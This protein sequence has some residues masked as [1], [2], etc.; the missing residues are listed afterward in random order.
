VLA[1]AL[2][3]RLVA[4]LAVGPELAPGADADDYVRIGK[5]IADGDGIP[6]HELMLNNGGPSALRPPAYPFTLGGIFAITG[7]SLAAARIAQALLGTVTVALLGLVAWQIFRRR[8]VA[9]A[10]MGITAIYPP[11]IGIG[12][13]LMTETLFLPLMLGSV[14]AAL[15]QRRVGGWRWAVAAGVLAGL[16]TL[17]RVSGVYL[18]LPL[19]LLVWTG[20]PLLSRAALR[21]VAAVAASAALV[22]A[23]WTIRNA[24]EFDAFV[25]VTTATGIAF[26][27]AFNPDTRED[28]DH[29]WLPAFAVPELQPLFNMPGLDEAE[30][31]GELSSY[32]REFAF[33]HPFYVVELAWSNLGRMLEIHGLSPRVEDAQLFGF[34]HED[35]DT[36]LF[37]AMHGL[38]TFGFYVL[39][40]L[41]IAGLWLGAWRR[42]PW[43]LWILP[44]GVF[45]G[46][47]LTIAA[48]RY[49]LPAD[50]L[51]ILLAAPPVARIRAAPAA[52]EEEAA[53]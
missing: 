38:N 26:A 40:A 51:L 39:A 32:A 4:A 17:T 10:A 44:A 3:I 52:E 22:V 14:A 50:A 2:T 9:L 46:A 28:P 11:F 8:D 36:G 34:S 30:L 5:S 49:R 25:P 12:A 48:T 1:V 15:E 18:V 6:T 45:A 23:P 13:A 29:L 41:A 19:L 35:K 47:L 33:D 37:K 43:P 24:I 27:G 31:S 42:I 21:P 53:N 20:R 16:A 7:D